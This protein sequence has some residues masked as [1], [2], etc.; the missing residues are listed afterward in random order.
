MHLGV[1]GGKQVCRAPEGVAG[2][3]G[4]RQVEAAHDG[5]SGD[6]LQNA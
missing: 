2:G 6:Q 1:Q 3:G 5:V 4:G